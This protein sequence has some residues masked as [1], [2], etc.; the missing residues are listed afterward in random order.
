ML[1]EKFQRQPDALVR[2]LD[3]EQV[4]GILDEAVVVDASG[5]AVALDDSKAGYRGGF[6]VGFRAAFIPSLLAWGRQFITAPREQGGSP[7]GSV[8]WGQ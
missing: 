6:A 5:Q 1:A 3:L 4:P 8:E 2:F 7:S